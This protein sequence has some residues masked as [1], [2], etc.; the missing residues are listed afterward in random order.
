MAAP[1]T[2]A[3]IL[4]PRPTKCPPIAVTRTE[5]RIPRMVFD[6][7]NTGCPSGQLAPLSSGR[8]NRSPKILFATK[9]VPFASISRNSNRSIIP[10][11]P[12]SVVELRAAEERG[13]SSSAG[14]RILPFNITSAA[15]KGARDE[16]RDRFVLNVSLLDVVRSYVAAHQLQSQSVSL[17]AL[18]ESFINSRPT[19]EKRAGELRQTLNKFADKSVM[20][21]DLDAKQIEVA[22]CLR[23]K[24]RK[25]FEC[26]YSN[27]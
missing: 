2:S 26:W 9:G 1:P 22:S 13:F 20:A 16:L 14:H 6:A 27:N 25:L 7:P 15:R 10:R 12:T 4:H 24:I 23:S 11:R 3:P 21:S 18:F 19:K 8:E 17:D 5:R